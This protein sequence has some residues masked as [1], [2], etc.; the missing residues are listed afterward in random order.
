M[1]QVQGGDNVHYSQIDRYVY[2]RYSVEQL[3]V[4]GYTFMSV[5]MV[6]GIKR[7]AAYGE[8]YDRQDG[9]NDHNNTEDICD[10]AEPFH[11]TEIVVKY[12][13][14]SFEK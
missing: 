6:P 11:G 8:E 7:C 2:R 12:Y 4:A 1:N 9:I 10:P 5:W 3:Q 13:E 14:G